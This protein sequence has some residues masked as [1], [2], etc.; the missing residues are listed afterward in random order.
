M[1]AFESYASHDGVNLQLS[2]KKR[3]FFRK[4]SIPLKIENWISDGDIDVRRGLVALADILQDE[5]D[6]TKDFIT[7]PFETVANFTEAEANALNLPKAIPYQLRIWSTGTLLDNTYVIQCEFVNNGKYIFLDNRVG[8]IQEQGAIHYRIPSPMFDVIELIKYFPDKK[9]EKLEAI[10]KISEILQLDA[11]SEDNFDPENSLANIR[12]RHAS[13]FSASIKGNLDDPEL[14]PVLFSKHVIQSGEDSD[15]VLDEIQQILTPAQAES[16]TNDFL[17]NETNSTYVLNTGEY[18]YIDPSISEILNAF[19]KI[20]HADKET[21]R[22]FIKSPRA[23]LTTH[24]PQDDGLSELLNSAFVETNQFSDR[25]IEINNWEAPDLPFLVTERNDWGTDV[26]IFEQ[27]GSNAPIIIPKDKLEATYNK[28]KQAHQSGESSINCNGNEISVNKE[29]IEQVQNHLPD[30]PQYTQDNTERSEDEPCVQGP[31]VIKTL[32]NFEAINYAKKQRPP[33]FLLSN[34]TPRN[35][36]P[37]TRLLEHQ[38]QGL[39][40]L[41]AAYNRGYPGVLIA[42]DMGLGKTLQALVFLALYQQQTGPSGRKPC[43]I[44]APTGLL[45]NW[46]NEVALHLG[47]GGLGN[48]QGVYGGEIRRLRTSS[49]KDIDTGAPLLNIEKIGRADVILTTYESL[50]DYQISFAQID[51][52]VVI[53]D[54]I[55]KAKNPKSLLSRSAATLN[56]RFQIGLSGTPVENSLADLWTIMDVLAPGLLDFD[57]KEFLDLFSGDPEETEVRKGLERLQKQLLFPD[58]GSIAPILRR[59]KNEVFKSKGP[60]GKPMP[61]KFIK[62]AEDTLELMSSEQSVSYST[63]SNSVQSKKI[64][65]IQALQSFKKISLSSRNPDLWLEDVEGTIRNSGRLK[66]S[67]RILDEIHKKKEKAL[68]FIESRAIQPLIAT[69]IKEKYKL[70]KL[71]LIINGAISGDAR[72]KAVDE[73][74]CGELNE[75]NAIIISPKAGGVGLTLTAANH[76]IHI[77]RWW[78]PAVEDQCNDRAYR[79]G[80]TK[81]VHI[82]TPVAKHPQLQD[83]SFDIVLDKILQRKRSLANSLFVPTELTAGD[84]SE[85]FDVDERKSIFQPISLQESYELESGEDF[86]NYVAGSLSNAGFKIRKTPRSH[87]GGCDL[88]A[89]MHN[90]NIICQVKQV[91]SPK[92]LSH[93]VEEIVAAKCR[94]PAANTLCLI[95]NSK[96][97]TGAQRTTA[98]KEGVILILGGSIQDI[99][100]VLRNETQ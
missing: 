4:N 82:Y 22:N 90:K 20:V 99:G 30:R 53:F 42:D 86:E 7:L 41:I 47:D 1:I 77:E 66:E 25:V 75:F 19:R 28:L 45:R 63:V 3:Q 84:F 62:P 59:M 70:K 2:K 48:I 85:M 27:L 65:M 51:F 33:S 23:T 97:V 94:Y 57:L 78:N 26:L 79:I 81:D 58:N 92:T 8:C 39:S 44:V 64:K 46:L 21:K 17:K 60:D 11:S 61:K 76:V 91:R 6:L 72:Q 67:F 29:I 69:I 16:F 12:L 56:G 80:A 37:K 24:L 73:F 43:L 18:V 54:E 98:K 93:G 95:T 36:L 10:S 49:G 50:R 13:G 15:K 9:N 38:S 40:W 83:K 96:K 55:Q 52:G 71:P 14:A 74:Q 35:L 34:E 31:F 89:E 87:D 88:I 5:D 32:D 100:L 68:I